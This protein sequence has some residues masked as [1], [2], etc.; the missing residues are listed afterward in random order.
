MLLLR[1]TW[2]LRMP[3][4]SHWS[5]EVQSYYDYFASLLTRVIIGHHSSMKDLDTGIV[6]ASHLNPTT[7]AAIKGITRELFVKLNHKENQHKQ[8][9]LDNVCYGISYK[10]QDNVERKASAVIKDAYLNQT[11]QF[12]VNKT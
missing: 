10:G 3:C 4:K 1:L 2:L 12:L 6:S 11:N 7:S 5:F 9:R 8:F